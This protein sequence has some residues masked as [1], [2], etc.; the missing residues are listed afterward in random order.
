MS[1]EKTSW[2]LIWWIWVNGSPHMATEEEAPAELRVRIGRDLHLSTIQR[3]EPMAT[4][5]QLGVKTSPA[6]DFSQAHKKKKDYST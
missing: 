6:G 1:K 2:Y 5:K 4:I 3:K